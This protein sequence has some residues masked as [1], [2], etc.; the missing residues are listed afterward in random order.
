[1]PK[2]RFSSEEI[3]HELREAEVLSV[4]GRTIAEISRQLSVTEQT[5]FRL[6]KG[7]GA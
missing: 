1:M 2:K 3:I 7:Y 6:R 4:Q 5:Y